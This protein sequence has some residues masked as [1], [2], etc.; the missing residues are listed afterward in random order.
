VLFN[1]ENLKIARKRRGVNK[2]YLAS[3]VDVDLR[4]VSSWE[5]GTA[6]PTPTNLAEL[7]KALDLPQDFFS[8]NIADMP[9]PEQVSFRAIS[10]LPASKRDMALAASS[11]AFSFEQWLEKSYDL[12]K[13]DVPDLR[14]INDVN[15]AAQILRNEWNQGNQPISNMI[16]LLESKG[17]R[18]FSLALDMTEVDAFCTWRGET[19][20]VFLNMKKSNARSRFDAAH[21]LAHLV[22]HR[23]GNY[24]GRETEREADQFASAFLMPRDG[25]I[26]TKPRLLD[27]NNSIK[28]KQE[29]GASLAAYIVRMNSLG[30]LTEWQYR[31]LFKQLSQRGYRKSE[32]SDH[33]KEQSKL[34]EF[35]LSDLRSEGISLLDISE[36]LKVSQSDLIDLCFDL[37]TIGMPSNPDLQNPREVSREHISVVVDN[38]RAN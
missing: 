12:P 17:V 8:A 28:A 32:P 26:P 2:T 27:L 29:W 9:D 31:S 23:H 18:V 35:I 19:P 3:L 16:H 38:T 13:F 22:L 5:A 37:A 21:E 20:F 14:H 15:E 11:I 36:E 33:R 7:G 25:V 10:K 1:P 34:L 4:S 6:I 24:S 30:Q